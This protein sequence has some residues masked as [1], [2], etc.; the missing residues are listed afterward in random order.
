MSSLLNVA[1][2]QALRQ[3]PMLVERYEPQIEA[4]LRSTLTALKAQH[5]DEA[6][7][8]HTNWMKLD[9]VVRSSLGTSAYSFVDTFYPRTAGR[10][11]RGK[12]TLRKKKSKY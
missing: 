12:R 11:R 7:L 10:S 5:P 4:N 8:F 2:Q 3:I 9:K 1:R 6:A